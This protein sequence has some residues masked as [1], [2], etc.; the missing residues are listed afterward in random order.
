MISA[1]IPT[2]IALVV[3]PLLMILAGA[4]DVLTLR[5]PNLL[6]VVLA[7][8]FLP[9]AA[10]S[11]M[12]LEA[13]W[14]HLAT[15]SVLLLFGFG[16]FAM[17]IFGGGDAKLMAAAGLWLGIPASVHFLLLTALAG[18]V[19]S[20]AVGLML[21]ASVDAEF[22]SSSLLHLIR[23]F[24]PDVPYGFAIAAGAILALPSSWWISNAA[25]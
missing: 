7:L 17:G 18:G 23:R 10:L 20:L 2:Q 19:L 14:L 1:A 4:S 5:I 24:K 25:A 9:F 11:G 8:A 3:F 13:I 6:T 15:G 12:S 21:V 22:R 16:L